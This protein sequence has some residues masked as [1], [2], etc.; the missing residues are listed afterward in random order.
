MCAQMVLCLDTEEK[1][2]FYN[3]ESICT[4]LCLLA[5]LHADKADQPGAADILQHA[6][7]RF[8]PHTQHAHLWQACEQSLAFERALLGGQWGEA[9]RAAHNLRAISGS[10]GR[11]HL[12]RLLRERGE[13]TA[14]LV[15][16]QTLKDECADSKD[17]TPDFLCRSVGFFFFHFLVVVGVVVVVVCCCCWSEGGVRRQQGA[18]A[19][20]PV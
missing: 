1:G 15:L 7:Q 11:L 14:S 19:G 18:H 12:A 17:L 6:R 2:V 10:E 9:E 5:R 13:V 8:P 3:G 4:S 20:L 16:L